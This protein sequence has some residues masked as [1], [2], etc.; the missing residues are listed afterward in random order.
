MTFGSPCRETGLDQ[1][2]DRIVNRKGCAPLHVACVD[3]HVARQK[4]FQR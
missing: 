4:M 3:H 2:M 1:S